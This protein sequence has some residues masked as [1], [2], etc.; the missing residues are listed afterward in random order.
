MT[1]ALERKLWGKLAATNDLVQ[2]NRFSGRVLDC[3]D[4]NARFA[5]CET[6][7]LPSS[8]GTFFAF[9]GMNKRM[10]MPVRE[11]FGA[12]SDLE[13][14][15]VFVKDFYQSW[16]QSGLFATTTNRRDTV[17]F[18]TE[19]FAGYPR[20]WKFV[21]TSSGAHAAIYFGAKMGADLVTAFAPQTYIDEITFSN[22]APFARQRSPFDFNDAGNDLLNVLRHCYD[23]D[24]KVPRIIIHYSQDNELDKLHAHH[25]RDV[26][27][28]TL[29][30]HPG[31]D[32]NL[33]KKLRG[34]GRLIETLMS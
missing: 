17:D 31:T 8:Q 1:T 26:A 2:K 25:V 18:L 4:P 24:L 10:G 20:P 32:H 21:G 19:R 28:V 13:H 12:L 27:A 9:G 16:Y 11:F 23:A 7:T 33:P 14:D 22:F 6:R 15:L 30:P 5:S 3:A 34:E 29:T